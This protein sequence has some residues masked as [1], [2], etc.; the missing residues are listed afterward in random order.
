[1]LLA[2]VHLWSVEE[3]TE[4]TPS[5]QDPGDLDYT[6]GTARSV[7]NY[8]MVISWGR[9]QCHGRFSSA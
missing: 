7:P 4:K 3:D 9:V 1:M 6:L 8:S 5:L 2:E